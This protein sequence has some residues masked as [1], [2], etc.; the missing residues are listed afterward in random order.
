MTRLIAGGGADSYC[1]PLR[2]DWNKQLSQKPHNGELSTE[3]I[4]SFSGIPPSPYPA[5]SGFLASSSTQGLSV[6]PVLYCLPE[7]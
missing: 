6:D 1:W 7:F 5:V 3:T 4:P 2:P